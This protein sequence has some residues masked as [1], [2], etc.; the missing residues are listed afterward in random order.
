MAYKKPRQ[1]AR[2]EIRAGGFFAAKRGGGSFTILS[3]ERGELNLGDEIR[4]ELSEE[5]QK[6][7]L[8]ASTGEK[9]TVTVE[10]WGCSKETAIDRLQ[11]FHPRA[12]VEFAKDPEPP[13]QLPD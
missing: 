3:L 12:E 6:E 13:T 10:D 5:G 7:V 1:S 9:I 2:V 4:G 8:N 11:N